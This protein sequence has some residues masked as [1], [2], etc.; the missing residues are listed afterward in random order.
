MLI[1]IIVVLGIIS[2]INMNIECFETLPNNT[3]IKVN[4]YKQI[5]I[6]N[7]NYKDIVDI[8]TA[9]SVDK[10]ILISEK[11]QNILTAINNIEGLLPNTYDRYKFKNIYTTE[12]VPILDSPNII[13]FNV[14]VNKLKQIIDSGIDS[15]FYN[16]RLTIKE[17]KESFI[18]LNKL[19]E[20]VYINKIFTYTEKK[21][22]IDALTRTIFDLLL[23]ITTM[24]DLNSSGIVL[25]LNVTL[26]IAYEQ[27]N[28]ID[29]NNNVNTFN[30]KIRNI[31]ILLNVDEKQIIE[32]EP[33]NIKK[34]DMDVNAS[35]TSPTTSISISTIK[36]D[37]NNIYNSFDTM[38]VI[39]NNNDILNIQQLNQLYDLKYIIYKSLENIANY[40]KYNKNY[41]DKIIVVTDVI[42]KPILESEIRIVYSSPKID[43]NIT[44]MKKKFY[45][46]LIEIKNI[47]LNNYS[48]T[49]KNTE[50]NICLK[51]V[52]D[53]VIANKY[54]IKVSNINECKESLFNDKDLVIY[55]KLA[56]SADNGKTW[57]FATDLYEYEKNG[58]KN[59]PYVFTYKLASTVNG[60]D[61]KFIST[62][63]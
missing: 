4:A 42:L 20:N 34:M 13:K 48:K 54:P 62:E 5:D 52:I 14:A 60:N 29:I 49:T 45:D 30:V 41:Y 39:Y 22:T 35:I 7:R 8:Y 17:I 26:K 37:F 12:I 32:P 9:N 55:P 59:T 28:T 3:E 27:N 21:Y 23:K 61:W 31:S 36:K 44:K 33:I 10:I 6:I 15:S 47:I 57:N 18:D 16:N 1:I 2:Y 51:N 25:I 50:K 40:D 63:G 38:N 58:V 46:G 56:I 24:E 53:N 19:Y 43:I 11:K